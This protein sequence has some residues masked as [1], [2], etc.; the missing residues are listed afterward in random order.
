LKT[1]I[2]QEI[3]RDREQ[4]LQEKNSQ[5]FFYK[6]EIEKIEKLHDDVE[7]EKLKLQKEEN[8]LLER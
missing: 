1:Q 2:K 6:N 5:E 3:A 7:N 4:L 8:R